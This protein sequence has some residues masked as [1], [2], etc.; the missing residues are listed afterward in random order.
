MRNL[1]FSCSKWK[2][3]GDSK[4]PLLDNQSKLRVF[5]FSVWTLW[6]L[7]GLSLLYSTIYRIF[8]DE[9]S[10]FEIE[11]VGTYFLKTGSFLQKIY[12]LQES[13][14]VAPFPNFK[15]LNQR[16]DLICKK[17]WQSTRSIEET[18]AMIWSLLLL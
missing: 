16:I 6:V 18:L 2:I 7:A 13:V 9:I 10:L 3:S 12:L 14:L 17:V 15:Y 4:L 11:I 5:C 1:H 8:G